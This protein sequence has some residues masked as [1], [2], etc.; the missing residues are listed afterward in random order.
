M[1]I[2]NMGIIA[3]KPYGLQV[4][5][6]HWPDDDEHVDEWLESLNAPV[7]NMLIGP[8]GCGK[9]TF[10]HNY[11]LQSRGSKATVS[12]R[13]QN[14][15]DPLLE[16]NIVDRYWS[17]QDLLECIANEEAIVLDQEN[18]V[19]KERER[20]LNMF[21]SHYW[22]VAIIWDLSDDELLHRG[23]SQSQI[24]E[25]EKIIERPDPDEDFDEL[26]YIFS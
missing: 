6:D 11:G 3:D 12:R 13:T 23:C 7:L 26:V 21:P 1:D 9:T 2:D 8:R 25:K 19:R 5:T 18:L 4:Q 20:F 24:E 16:L 10:I 22:K 14:V 15:T 17:D